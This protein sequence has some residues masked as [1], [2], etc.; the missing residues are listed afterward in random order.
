ML[1]L[2]GLL[3]AAVAI[4]LLAGACSSGKAQPTPQSSTVVATVPASKVNAAPT[5]AAAPAKSD[6]Y[7]VVVTGGMIKK[8]DWPAVLPSDFSVPANATV[9]VHVLNFDDP[10]DMSA[11]DMVQ[12][13]KVTGTVG[14]TVTV[15]PV[16]DADPNKLGTAQ[17][18]SQLDPK[19]GVSHTLTIPQLG[20]NVPIAPHGWT[21]FTIHT[22]AAGSYTWQCM[23]PCGTDPN[24]MG[25]P[26]I[27]PGYMKGTMTVA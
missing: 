14:N 8:K 27:T 6:V 20:L 26:M 23:V 16:S 21:T 25:G 12:Y 10:D 18:L 4:P 5:V 17:T 13:T 15:Q 19:T 3:A 11:A 24:G 9:T 22:G 7:L 2:G 1:R